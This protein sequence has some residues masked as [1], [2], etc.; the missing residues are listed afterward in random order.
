MMVQ[1]HLVGELHVPPSSITETTR[2]MMDLRMDSLDLV[3]LDARVVEWVEQYYG[4]EVT[5]PAL[6]RET[7]GQILDF[8]EGQADD[9]RV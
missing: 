1:A 5:S 8:I 4:R 6:Q 9:D 3:T 2:I 7:I